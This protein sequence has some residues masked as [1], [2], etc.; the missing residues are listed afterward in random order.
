MAIFQAFYLALAENVTFILVRF[1]WL[2][3]DTSI[4]LRSFN[5]L[6]DKNPYELIR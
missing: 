3:K 6:E 1:A 5:D 4:L 2:I